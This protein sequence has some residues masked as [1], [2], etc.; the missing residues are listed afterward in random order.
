MGDRD[1]NGGE[2]PLGDFV[3]KGAEHFGTGYVKGQVVKHV[4]GETVSRP[5]G[6]LSDMF[7]VQ[8]LGDREAELLREQWRADYAMQ[9]GLPPFAPP[10]TSKNGSSSKMKN[11]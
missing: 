2:K 5:F 1:N 7:S 10:E 6:F 11:K 8:P 9:N 4:A 3:K